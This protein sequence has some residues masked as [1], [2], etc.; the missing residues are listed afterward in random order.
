V[1]A[2]DYPQVDFSK[3]EELRQLVRAAR[4]DLIINPAAY[5]AVDRAETESELAY[6]VNAHS[7]AVLAEEALRLRVPLVHY[8]TDYVFDGAKGSPYLESD[9][10]APLNVYGHSKLAGDRASYHG[11]STHNPADQLGLFH[12]PGWFR[13]QS[14]AVV[15]QQEVLRVVADQISGRPRRACWLN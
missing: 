3:P 12:A 8:S 7:P 4:P 2:L 15:A 11:R 10:P 14:A 6:R 13:H 9:E 1:L 5:T